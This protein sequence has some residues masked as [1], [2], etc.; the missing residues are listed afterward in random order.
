MS[1]AIFRF[2]CKLPQAECLLILLQPYLFVLQYWSPHAVSVG[3]IVLPLHS[4]VRH[5]PPNF[6]RNTDDDLA[7]GLPP[8]AD[9]GQGP[10]ILPRPS[11]ILPLVR[12]GADAHKG[13]PKEFFIIFS[14]PPYTTGTEE[15]NKA[16]SMPHIAVL[17][18]VDRAILSCL[19]NEALELRSL[20]NAQTIT[21][22]P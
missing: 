4:R 9:H 12:Y 2:I 13:T 18:F 14:N 8:E 6:L 5:I 3:D 16:A 11:L 10:V 7:A 17:L 1:K 19:T 21:L 15:L 20:R 22:I